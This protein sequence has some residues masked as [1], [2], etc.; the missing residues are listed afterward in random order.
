M[1]SL[2]R[3]VKLRFFYDDSLRQWTKADLSTEESEQLSEV[4]QHDRRHEQGP[5]R[6]LRSCEAAERQ[7]WIGMC[8]CTTLDTVADTFLLLSKR[9]I[10]VV[11]SPARGT[12]R[13]VYH[14]LEELSHVLTRLLRHRYRKFIDT[15]LMTWSKWSWKRQQFRVHGIRWKIRQRTWSVLLANLLNWSIKRTRRSDVLDTDYECKTVWM[16]WNWKSWQ[17]LGKKSHDVVITCCSFKTRSQIN[18][19]G[20]VTEFT[21]AQKV[22]PW[23][24]T[25]SPQR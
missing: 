20:T 3:C 19:Q 1:T 9:N 4:S 12:S 2:T 14:F 6:D 18:W 10:R 17:Y 23:V 11:K 16:R 5:M 13:S 21:D 7:Q 15:T 22:I 24:E 25:S 8:I